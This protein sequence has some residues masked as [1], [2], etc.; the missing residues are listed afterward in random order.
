MLLSLSLISNGET[1]AAPFAINAGGPAYTN[2]M[3]G[4]NYQADAFYSGGIAASVPGAT[5]T[6][7][8]DPTLYLTERYGKTFSYNI[9]AP[10][11]TYTVIL[12]FAE[13]YW[14]QPGQRKFNV[15]VQGNE[16]IT[17]LDIIASAGGKD[18]AYDVPIPNV[19]VTNGM[20]NI[21]FTTVVDNAKV[22]AIEIFQG[23]PSPPTSSIYGMF[24]TTNGNIAVGQGFTVNQGA[25]WNITFTDP[26]QHHGKWPACLVTPGYSDTYP[27]SAP[28][29][30]AYCSWTYADT[31]IKFNYVGSYDGYIC[32]RDASGIV[33]S[34]P[35][36]PLSISFYCQW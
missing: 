27:S 32:C 36:G 31:D 12:Q 23:T 13:I 19:N 10:N 11:G 17:G 22:S 9:P 6:G 3:Y 8:T 21:S 34:P 25:C 15:F 33:Q 26:S 1:Y 29:Q 24:Y 20:L 16:V 28:Y 2:I 7:T 18:I 5:I 35:E 14:N 30:S 4:T